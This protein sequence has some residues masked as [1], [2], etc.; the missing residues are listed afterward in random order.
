MNSEPELVVGQCDSDSAEE[1]ALRRQLEKLQV[2]G[3]CSAASR[4]VVEQAELKHVSRQ[5]G[6]LS[7]VSLCG[8]ARSRLVCS[9][10]ATTWKKKC[11]GCS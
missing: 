7:M 5:S 8:C 1:A 9:R 4:G 6:E 11:G 3:T 10:S 2:R